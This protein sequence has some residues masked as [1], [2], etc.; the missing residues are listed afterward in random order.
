MYI[1]K[2]ENSF[3]VSNVKEDAVIRLL[4]P[5]LEING[6]EYSMEETAPLCYK[7][8]A[9]E[10]ADTVTDLG[11]GLFSVERRI[12][13]TSRGRRTLKVI[14]EI[15]TCYIPKKSTIPCIMFDGNKRSRS[16]EPQGLTKDGESWIFGY[17]RVSI[18]S[19]TITETKEVSAA[20]FASVRDHDS[21]HSSCSFVE[22][23][24]KSYRHRIFY[25]MTE[26]PL[27]YSGHNEYEPRYDEYL[28]IEPFGT[29]TAE[30][31]I[32]IAVPY[33]ENYGTAPLLDRCLELF[34]FKHKPAL[35]V[36]LAHDTSLAFVEY[37][38]GRAKDG[39]KMF[40]NCMTP[41]PANPEGFYFKYENYEAGW[42]GQC[43]Q[44]ARL[45]ILEYIK[46]GRKDLLTY[47]IDCLDAWM[48]TKTSTGLFNRSYQNYVA[49]RDTKGDVC[50]IS[51]GAAEAVRAYGL[52][53]SIGIEKPEYLAFA[54]GICDFF[55]SHY[56]DENGFG[57]IWNVNTGAPEAMGGS[58]GSFA[59][60]ALID[61]YKETKEK[62]YLDCAITAIERYYRY[63]LNDFACTAGAIDCSC[64]DK[65]TAGPFVY[66]T[67]ELYE[68]TGEKIYLEYALKAAYY[69]S[70]WMYHYDAEYPEDSEFNRY[71]FYTYGST[72]VSTQHPA[73]DSW[74]SFVVA[75]F[76]RLW[77]YTGDERWKKRAQ[78]LW[79]SCILCITTDT[80]KVIR[81]RKRPWG[82]QNEAFLQCRWARPT[83]MPT[84][85]TYGSL[86]DL[87]ANWTATFRLVT[88]DRTEALF[89]SADILTQID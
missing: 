63:D 89:G 62:I 73:L 83:Y 2:S 12:K 52:L 71:G 25:P 54:R 9:F 56:T 38:M 67:C 39:A 21:I 70:S 24:D 1:V 81:G 45:C 28:S 4:P 82:L 60:M 17:N 51:W 85:E 20:L 10:A 87:F 19:C 22:N 77:K 46:N 79:C 68:I 78:M 37:V 44:C 16:V 40:R 57:L 49:G 27:T 36:K 64:V 59:I 5:A 31:Y 53:K 26:A 50:N 6:R 55:V 41:D 3:A 34:P 32:Y 29:F 66:C 61:F 47:G 88:L 69:F 14:A 74:G 33:W 8:E 65:E 72:A 43:F 75:D 30:F 11:G 80:E 35:G 7:G 15:E 48:K 58:I 42:S 23:K 18:P 84:L 13:N 86:N 76:L